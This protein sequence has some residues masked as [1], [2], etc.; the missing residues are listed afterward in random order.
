MVPVYVKTVAY[1]ESLITSKA[2]LSFA[3]CSVQYSKFEVLQ[4]L[5]NN[6][7]VVRFFETCGKHWVVSTHPSGFVD[8]NSWKL[9]QDRNETAMALN[10]LLALNALHKKQVCSH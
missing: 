4:H 8:G 10:F 3:Y 5:E 9:R 6:E 2:N 1:A 7:L